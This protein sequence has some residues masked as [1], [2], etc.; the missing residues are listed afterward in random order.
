M[1][2]CLQHP[3]RELQMI[4][5]VHIYFLSDFRDDLTGFDSI[6]QKRRKTQAELPARREPVTLTV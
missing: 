5:H 6:V 3:D 4:L 1:I 2:K